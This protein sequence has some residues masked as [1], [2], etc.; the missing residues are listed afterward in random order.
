LLLDGLLVVFILA[1]STNETIH[2]H[3]DPSRTSQPTD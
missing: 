3:T 1:L 2:P